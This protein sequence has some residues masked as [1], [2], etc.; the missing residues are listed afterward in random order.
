MEE[1]QNCANPQKNEKQILANSRLV[2][3]LPVCN[4]IFERLTYNPMFNIKWHQ[5]FVTQ[6]ISSLHRSLMHKSAFVNSYSIVPSFDKGMKNRSIF[7]G[8]SKAFDKV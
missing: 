2:A 8:I 3:L 1:S 6:P 4:K 5:Y 7:L